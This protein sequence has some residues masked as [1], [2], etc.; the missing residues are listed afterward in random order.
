[1][2]P[3]DKNNYKQFN[4]QD[5]DA[6][7][8]IETE[9][10]IHSFTNHHN[11]RYEPTHY[12]DLLMIIEIIQKNNLYQYPNY[13][14]TLVD[15]GSGLL[16]VPITFQYFLNFKVKGIELNKQLYLFSLNNL[17]QYQLEHQNTSINVYNLNALDYQFKIDDTHLFFFNPFSEHIFKKVI[18][19][20][21]E[22]LESNE[23][24]L[25]K[26]KHYIILYFPTYEYELLMS[27]YPQFQCIE[28]LHLEDF[29]IDSREKVL[30]FEYK[31]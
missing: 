19:S 8:R 18:E 20:Y 13:Q 26:L 24:N 16:R 2:R 7:L 22:M 1:M 4:S 10:A 31:N 12:H 3:I 25:Q 28:T 30:F 17:S 15:F 9:N 23:E 11:N 29:D 27:F 5:F 21:I 14:N 6:L